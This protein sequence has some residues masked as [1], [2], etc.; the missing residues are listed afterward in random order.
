[1]SAQ[2]PDPIAE[3]TSS[4][5]APEWSVS[6]L[7]FA[8]KRTLE[9]AFGFVRLRGEISGFKR[10]SSGHCYFTLK[11]ENAN[12]DA[13]MWRGNAAR[14]RFR[15]ED[16]LEVIAQGKITT[17][18]GRSKYQIVVDSLEPAGVG[19]LMALLEER[20][21]A[22]AAEGLF[23]A[24][25]KRAI[26][27]LP[28]VI[29]VVTSPT[30]AVIRD[31]LHRL[32]DRF[33]RRV[34][35]WP[36]AVQGEGAAAQVAAAIRGFN[37]LAPAGPVP[38]P[39]VLIVARGGGSLEDLWAFNEEVVVRAAAESAIPL[40]SAVGH[41]T[42]TTLID[43]ASDRRAPT[44]TAAAEMAVPVR[45]DLLATVADFARR[46]H[47][48]AARLMT[49]RREKVRGLARA[50][51][52]PDDLL[53]LASQRLDTAR[54]RLPRALKGLLDKGRADLGVRGALRPAVLS[55]MAEDRRARL[56]DVAARLARA[57]GRAAADTREA[58][59]RD[60]QRLVE[61]QARSTRAVRQRIAVS[62]ERLTATA[63]LLDTLSY[64]ATL[65]RGFALV[66]DAD[67]RPVHAAAG[68][69]GGVALDIEFA[70]GHVRATAEGG[71]GPTL[72][73]Q[74][75]QPKPPTPAKQQG[76]LF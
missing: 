73:K 1:M 22:L 33:P 60:R 43:F 2:P 4:S 5:N 74:K 49:E 7:S 57:R 25:R 6:E 27:F 61:L 15:P 3:P 66:R 38:R 54:D 50:L 32:D 9:D 26:P 72:P 76:S 37:A 45:A 19:A 47:A 30:G 20:R 36:V 65:A 14:L 42:D 70:D 34:L 75:A 10:H 12:I 21:K 59:A 46:Q 48:A 64:R 56:D 8:L 41:E 17:Y 31:I 13:V 67:G 63:K 69:A 16:G 68:I 44:P 39:D 51:P 11:D 71:G 23:D 24:D 29:G 62:A 52:R 55:R 35:V 58:L 28:R 53:A 40:I 18:P